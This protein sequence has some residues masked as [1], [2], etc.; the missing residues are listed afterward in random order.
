M[1]HVATEQQLDLGMSLEALQQLVGILHPVG[2]EPGR[3]H[4]HYRVVQAQDGRQ[5][6]A[7]R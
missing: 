4:R 2:V 6:R 3:A 5:V 1:M 7:L